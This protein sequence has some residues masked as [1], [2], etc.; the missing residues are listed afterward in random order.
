MDYTEYEINKIY[1]IYLKTKKQYASPYNLLHSENPYFIFRSI[2]YNN[3][4]SKYS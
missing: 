2:L 4:R 1:Y 3:N